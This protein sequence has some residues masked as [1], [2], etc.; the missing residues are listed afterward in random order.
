MPFFILLLCY[1]P[2]RENMSQE[3][4]TPTRALDG[5]EPEGM[6]SSDRKDDPSGILCAESDTDKAASDSKLFV[7]PIVSPERIRLMK[8]FNQ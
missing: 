2:F 5:T 3:S 7:T 8:Y 4:C 1:Y 6:S